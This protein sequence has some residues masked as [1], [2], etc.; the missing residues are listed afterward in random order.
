VKEKILQQGADEDQGL[1]LLSLEGQDEVLSCV[2]PHPALTRKGVSSSPA[3]FAS[4]HS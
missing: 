2:R 4:Q 3:N 1:W